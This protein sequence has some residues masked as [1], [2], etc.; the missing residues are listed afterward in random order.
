MLGQRKLRDVDDIVHHA[1]AIRHQPAQPLEVEPRLGSER[2]VDQARQVDRAQQAR[3]VRRQRLLATR[4]RR[5]YLFAVIEVVPPV[6][7]V[8]ED[9]AR[10]GIGVS[11][12]HDLVPQLARRKHLPRG[13]SAIRAAEGQLPWGIFLDRLHEGVR[14]QHR[15]VEHA[16]PARLELCFDEG[17]DVGVVAAQGRHHRAAAVAGA[18]DRAAHRVPHIHEGERPRGIGADAL[19]RRTARPQGREIVADAAAL[20]HR[21]RGFAQMRKDPA[22]VIGDDAHHKTV[23][24]GHRAG[25]AGAGDD[26]ARGQKFEIGQRRIEPLGAGRGVAFGRG[27]RGRHP[28]PGILDRLVDHLA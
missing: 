2:L 15:E 22:H 9:H 3:A 14:H 4:V 12:A 1:D 20:L 5:G 28:P 11:R 10:L 27:E 13:L 18:H 17:L 16:Q 26:A 8:D 7:A 25:A 19:D 23:E 6:D 21:Q 24:E